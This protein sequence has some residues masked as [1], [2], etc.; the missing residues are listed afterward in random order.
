MFE[1]PSPMR[2]SSSSPSTDPVLVEERLER[3]ARTISGASSSR[4]ASSRV[5]T[6]SVA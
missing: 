1:W 3:L 4:S 2:S 6:M 5:S